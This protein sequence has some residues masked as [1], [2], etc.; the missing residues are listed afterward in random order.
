MPFERR[1]PGDH[2]VHSATEIN[3]WNDAA[4]A[5]RDTQRSIATIEGSNLP[6]GV[7][8]VRNDSG[9]DRERFEVLALDAPLFAD[10]STGFKQVP[11]F[12]GVKPD[13]EN[14][15]SHRSRVAILAAPLAK[16]AIGR[17]YI[18][19]R[20]WMTMQVLDVAHTR[21]RVLDNHK[22][23]SGYFG[24]VR[25]LGCNTASDE[26]LCLV[27]IDWH[28]GGHCWVRVPTGGIPAGT[29]AAPS[30]TTCVLAW[31]HPTTRAITDVPSS[32][33]RNVKVV[34]HGPAISAGAN[35]AIQCRINSGLLVPDVE[36][37]S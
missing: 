22:L 17:A 11:A 32:K 8:L 16:D 6:F 29:F 24:P 13:P 28:D 20:M 15:A 9:Q 12:K 21:A 26:A 1:K 4:L 7:V 18:R 33:P 35:K 31:P 37:C 23:Q 34:H 30:I 10:N 5:H 19:G 2:V 14:K 3:A 25:I 36:Y 27:D